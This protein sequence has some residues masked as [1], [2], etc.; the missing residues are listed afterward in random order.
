MF[1]SGFSPR[2]EDDASPSPRA[3]TSIKSLLIMQA[4]CCVLS[5]AICGVLYGVGHTTN[6]TPNLRTQRTVALSRPALDTVR[7]FL[8]APRSIVACRDPLPLLGTQESGVTSTGMYV[9]M[10]KS[11]AF[12]L[13]IKG[14]QCGVEECG[15]MRAGAASLQ[16]GTWPS[17]EASFGTTQ[18]EFVRGPQ[19]ANIHGVRPG[20]EKPI[21]SRTA[22]VN[23]RRSHHAARTCKHGG[24]ECNLC[25]TEPVVPMAGREGPRSN[26]RDRPGIHGFVSDGCW[27]LVV[28]GC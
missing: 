23:R 2:Q 18:A 13:I 6:W 4:L 3:T 12:R 27:L 25:P 19:V 15:P 1:A 7:F 22:R 17:T 16:L 24:M 21:G 11:P 14:S 28:V 20:R 26:T 10:F 8:C 9:V 5:G